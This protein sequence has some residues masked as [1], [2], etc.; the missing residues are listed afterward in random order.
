M[1][2]IRISKNSLKEYAQPAVFTAAIISLTTLNLAQSQ[3]INEKEKQLAMIQYSVPFR[4]DNTLEVG[5]W[6]KYQI[7][8]EGEPKK[9]TELRVTQ[10][11]DGGVWIVEKNFEGE[12][13]KGLA[14]HLLVDLDNLKLI[15]VSAVDQSGKKRDAQPMDEKRL[16]QIIEMGKE[17]AHAEMTD[18]IGWSKGAGTEEVAVAGKVL[19]CNFLEPEYSEDYIEKIEDYGA[20]VV[21]AKEKSRLYFNEA[22]P[23]LLPTQIA[24][25]W[26]PF[27][28]TFE[29]VEGGFVKSAQM[30][31]ELVGCS[32]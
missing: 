18:I 20:T 8:T 32:D 27:I 30:N 19:E 12:V 24:M 1:S 22:V 17:I 10:K 3:D 15:K 21:E 4:L 7:T 31:L 25:G 16:V 28:E 11:E 14:M 9:I 26:I 2:V 13:Q 23:R 29:D 5:D 6:V